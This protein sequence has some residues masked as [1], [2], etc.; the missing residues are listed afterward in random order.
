VFRY[1]KLAAVLI[2]D[3]RDFVR[4]ETARLIDDFLFIHPHQRPEDRQLRCSLD[5]RHIVQG[6]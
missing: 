2:R 3:G 1:E 6:L 4:A 5:H